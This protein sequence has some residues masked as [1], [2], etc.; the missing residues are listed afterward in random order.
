MNKIIIIG[1][2]ISGLSAA[3]YLA[4]AGFEVEIYEK[5]PQAGGRARQLKKN[6][7]MF[8][9]G[10][11]F[12]WMPDVFEKFFNDFGKKTSDY[13]ELIRLNPGYEVYLG[14]KD[15]IAL[16][17][18]RKGIEAV[19]EKYEPGSSKFLRKFLREA[20]YNYRVAMDKVVYQPGKS[21]LELI[22]PATA[23]RATQFLSSLSRTVRK[24]IRN[25]QLQQI[26]E[27][28]VLFLGAKPSDIPAFYCFMNYAD[29]EMGTWHIRGGMY[30]LIEA[31]QHLAESMGVKIHTGSPV[32]KIEI[33]N[34]KATSIIVHK[35]RIPARAVISGADYHY[36]EQLIENTHRNY[37]E[38]YWQSRVMAP[39]ALLYYM[40]FN[41]QLEHVSH[42]TLF[43]DTDFSVHAENIYDTPAWPETPLFYAS[44]PS[45]TDPSFAPSGKEAGIFLIPVASGLKDTP[46]IRRKYF[47]QIIERMENLTNQSLKKEVLFYESY[48]FSDFIRDY[49]AYKGNAYGLANIFLQTAFL[50]PKI[51]NK[52]VK[53]LFYTG[54][55][56]VPGPG[57]PPAIISG[58]V[59]ANE[60]IKFLSGNAQ[61]KK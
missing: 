9:M 15:S 20:G 51:R 35:E 16:P 54:Q 37:S 43:F 29:M 31:M 50:K 59:V 48:A 24:N 18:D 44:F 58:K 7:F 10:P 39:S 47:E 13:Y 32:E 56:T 12:Y 49:H 23:K 60:A 4:K 34:G 1:A 30:K 14:K 6:G 61:L 21:P 26:L 8:D 25:H 11:T 42:H 3:C 45:K 41:K 52:S 53:N 19:F 28:P 2:G 5:N 17:A 55:L 38:K 57:V 46:G 36:T 27:F 22:M 33:T 40:A